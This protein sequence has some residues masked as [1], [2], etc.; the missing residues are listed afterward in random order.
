MTKLFGR[1]PDSRVSAGLFFTRLVA[2][3]ALI[4][5]GWPKV[6]RGLTSWMG[7]NSPVPGWL[8]F[9]AVASE[10]GGGAA[11]ILGLL[12]PIASFGVFCTMAYATY[13]HI[14]R[15]DP[16]V[17]SGSSYEKAL[18]LLTV[19]VLMIIA[20]PGKF[21]LDYLLFGRKRDTA[22]SEA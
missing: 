21:S 16:F 8:Q 10:V 7:E 15:G 4:L 12:T 1:F 11:L 17:G 13:T 2:G 5:H 9:L 14:G 22:Y 3:V 6:G 19:A 18:M 20:G